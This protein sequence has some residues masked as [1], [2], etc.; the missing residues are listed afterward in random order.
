LFHH[1]CGFRPNLVVILAVHVQGR[2][3]AH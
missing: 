1:H 2:A 3:S